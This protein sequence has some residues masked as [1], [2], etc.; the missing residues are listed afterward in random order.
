METLEIEFHGNGQS[1]ISSHSLVCAILNNYRKLF[2]ARGEFSFVTITKREIA[3]QQL[4]NLGFE[5]KRAE[6]L[7]LGV[8]T[9]IKRDSDDF[10]SSDWFHE[11]NMKNYCNY[12][13]FDILFNLKLQS[14]TITENRLMY[15]RKL[16]VN[17]KEIMLFDS[18]CN[19][20]L[21]LSM[22][23]KLKLEE[24]SH[25]NNRK[26]NQQHQSSHK[27]RSSVS[28]SD[29]STR[30]INKI[31]ML[32]KSNS[33][34]VD[35]DIEDYNHRMSSVSKAFDIHNFL[36]NSF[37]LLFV[38]KD[39]NNNFGEGGNTLHELYSS[40]DTSQTSKRESDMTV[41]LHNVEYLISS[42]CI[43]SVI[44]QLISAVSRVK[45]HYFGI[46]QQFENQYKIKK[47]A[48]SNFYKTNKT[49]D[50][51][52]EILLRHINKR[53]VHETELEERGNNKK[54][55]V[56]KRD[57]I[58]LNLRLSIK[59][60]AIILLS[61]QNFLAKGTI[62]LFEFEGKDLY[63][64]SDELHIVSTIRSIRVFDMSE[65]S[66]VHPE[67]IWKNR[68]KESL[69]LISAKILRNSCSPE[70]SRFCL[71][72]EIDGLSICFLFRFVIDVIDFLNIGLIGPISAIFKR[73][74]E[75]IK[76]SLSKAH[77]N[78]GFDDDLSSLQKS[79][80]SKVSE[81]DVE[82]YFGLDSDVYNNSNVSDDDSHSFVS[83]PSIAST[84]NEFTNNHSNI[85]SN[86]KTDNADA[87]EGM[88]RISEDSVSD[89]F[90]SFNFRVVFRDLS[91]VLPRNSNSFDLLGVKIESATMITSHVEKSW[92]VPLYKSVDPS[93]ELSPDED[94]T[95]YPLHFD[96]LSNK[97]RFKK[98]RGESEDDRNE[99]WNISNHKY[100]TKKSLSTVVEENE[101][102]EFS[103]NVDQ[104]DLESKNSKENVKTEQE[105]LPNKNNLPNV[106]R[107]S[108]IA[109]HV[110]IFCSLSGPFKKNKN[111][112]D[113]MKSFNP[114]Q[115]KLF[116]EIDD[117]KPVNYFMDRSFVAS[118][119]SRNWSQQQN[120]NKLSLN[121]FNLTLIFDS[122]VDQTRILITDTDSFSVFN[123]VAAQSELYLLLA[124]VW[125]ENFNE[126]SQFP[127]EASA[128][129][130]AS[131]ANKNMETSSKIP[132]PIDQIK[133]ALSRYG[134]RE[135]LRFLLN[136]E[137]S[138][139]LA[140]VRSEI[141]LGF[142]PHLHLPYLQVR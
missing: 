130:R 76:H 45:S 41:S 12:D 63:N 1:K 105:K 141:K 43:L 132:H 61:E 74:D 59:S 124:A 30:K 139:E 19:P 55:V 31:R 38:E 75:Q 69:Q 84:L 102:E 65:F 3:M 57:F 9:S 62:E 77:D 85:P 125:F 128:V 8:S 32:T 122:T 131:E 37:V 71:S 91:V 129:E 67:V 127:L 135:Y 140:I 68:E 54:E 24:F 35:H 46:L 22:E 116:A 82:D 120:W 108:L 83:E 44:K 47:E 34:V 53:F 110:N 136:R 40:P 39:Y 60:L 113:L 58:H 17:I 97:L 52:L 16:L 23:P 107:I 26:S 42:T 73:A 81:L 101:N 119:S 115:H 48:A 100:S 29:N 134:S 87:P 126:L 66:M 121:D 88:E 27:S 56:I 112:T 21:S 20:I 2:I 94:G 95:L 86:I 79:D 5:R 7:L 72:L 51:F 64:Y 28:V 4:L 111:E 106:L 36:S 138:F 96:I 10:F 90:N 93:D 18:E 99:Q 13:T 80:E 6:V 11:S 78:D 98:S 50:S 142:G 118:E 137:H 133:E 25:L 33:V 89:N 92:E 117:R 109:Q 123:L 70:G 103:D 114:N 14:I 104:F 15:D 49:I